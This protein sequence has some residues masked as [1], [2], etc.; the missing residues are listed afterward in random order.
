MTPVGRRQRAR[1]VVRAGQGDARARPDQPLAQRHQP[2]VIARRAGFDRAPARGRRAP[3]ARRGR[4]AGRR[5]RFPSAHS[6]RRRD[7]RPRRAAAPADPPRRPAPAPAP[8]G[9]WLAPAAPPAPEIA[10]CG[11]AARHWRYPAR[12]PAPRRR[13]WRGR[14]PRRARLD[15]ENSGTSSASRRNTLDGRGIGRRQPRQRIGEGVRLV[16]DGLARRLSRAK[17]LRHALR[18]RLQLLARLAV[19][20]RVEGGGERGGRR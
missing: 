10:G 1:P 18:A 3:T 5:R 11:R 9:D 19:E 16:A 17:A 8:H 12:F 20:Q 7:R 4:R 15:G 13:R 6:S 2:R 14:S